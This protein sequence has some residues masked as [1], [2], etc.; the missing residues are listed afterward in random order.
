MYYYMYIVHEIIQKATI[1]SLKFGNFTSFKIFWE[2]LLILI[3]NISLFVVCVNCY[4]VL[5]GD[6]LGYYN[7][8]Q[9]FI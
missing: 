7:E 5:S 3:Y 6:Y 9:K 4:C 1:S 2:N 8:P